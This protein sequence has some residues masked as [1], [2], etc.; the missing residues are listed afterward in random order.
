MDGKLY[1]ISITGLNHYYGI[2]PFHVGDFFTLV[3]E[4]DNLYDHHAIMVKAPLLGKIGYVANSYYTVVDGTMGA[5]ELYKHVPEECVAQIMFMT[6]SSIIAKV[7]PDVKLK[8][9]ISVTLEKINNEDNMGESIK[10]NVTDN[11]FANKGTIT[12][13]KEELSRLLG[14]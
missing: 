2:N 3:K 1:F 4:P 5:S 6:S 9:D 12:L 13:T 14:E 8:V 11:K 10:D 7:L